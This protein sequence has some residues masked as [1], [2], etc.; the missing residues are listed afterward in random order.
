MPLST[1]TP[2]PFTHVRFT[3]AFWAPRIRTNNTVTMRHIY[4]KLVESGRIE[5]F[6]LVKRPKP[7]PIVY[8]F[9][10]SDVAKWI[11]AA[12]Y[13]LATDPDPALEA[14]LD[15]VV[16]LVVS[17]QQP[18]GYLNTHFIASDPAMRW[19]N[20]RDWHELYCAGHLMEG[21]VAHA[22]TTGSTRLLDA[23]SRYADHID[24]QFGREEGKKRGYGG[25]PEIELALVRL[26]QA[27][28]QQRYLNLARYFVEERGQPDPHYYDVEA[29][30][31]GEDPAKFWA[32]SYEYNQ[33]HV[34]VREQQKVVGH[35]VRAMYLFS[36]VADLAAEL[37]DESLLET[38]RRLWD[39]L[40]G[41]RMYI[42]G[43]IG[44]SRHN[45][46]FTEDY[47]LPD[48]SAYAETCAT[49]GMVL[50]NQRLLQF[51][52]TAGLPPASRFA[53]LVER[54]LYNGFLSGV[55]L[56]GT[57]FF[58]DNPL[59]SRGAHHREPWFY[60]PCCP[61]N[62]ARVLASLGQYIYSTG[63]A[64]LWVHQF[65]GS[66]SEVILDDQLV[67]VTQTTAYPWDGT[68]T[69]TVQPEAPQTFT[70]H[71]RLPGWCEQV[72]LEVNGQAVEAAALEPAT[73]YFAIRREWQP[74]D[75]VTY[76]M[77]MPPRA[78]FANRSV[79]DLQGRFAIQRGPIVYCLEG[80]DHEGILLDR[81]SVDPAAVAGL[82]IDPQPELL[83]GVTLLRGTAYRL[84]ESGDEL[85]SS[86]PLTETAVPLTA[87]PYCV[88]DHRA[89]GE[90]R[91]WLRARQGGEQGR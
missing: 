89:A 31:R 58:Y 1:L 27:T 30:A 67:R 79:R 47:D 72:K 82:Q 35:A 40:T 13:A 41:K 51:A 15:E 62:V 33:S 61:P 90:M 84:E 21:A 80:A 75:S 86:V 3:D 8:I 83:G 74:G 18:D 59:A 22:E 12:S 24:G 66:Q 60:C 5:S 57:G 9:G 10:D 87:V 25:H 23:L 32:K 69:L 28:G 70:L 43:G 19:K 16:E 11:E 39:N 26:Y 45:E 78:V 77:E 65:A 64:A 38:C 36:G 50:W 4:D 44:P 55:S 85:Y 81:L 2:V 56:D 42:T 52:G 17:A 34:P 73:G 63:E 14:L 7:V 48:E 91:V 68:V 29:R 46:G 37:D 20:L 76:R 88:W 6:R 53:D 49:I 54:G 71:L